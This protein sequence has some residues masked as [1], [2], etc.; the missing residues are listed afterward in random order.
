MTI[1]GAPKT[2]PANVTHHAISIGTY[3]STDFPPMVKKLH[4]L[5][6]EG[7]LKPQQ[8]EE[9]PNGLRGIEVGLERLKKGVSGVKLVAV[10]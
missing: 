2:I 5:V 1:S 10:L 4:F 7:K 8:H 9:L 3:D 6:A